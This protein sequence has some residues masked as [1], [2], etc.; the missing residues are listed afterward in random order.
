[1]KTKIVIVGLGGVGG[2]YGGMLAKNHID[3]PEIEIYFVAR[4]KHLK[5]VQENG[6]TLITENGTFQVVP[7][8]A[9]DNVTEIGTADYI[10]MTPKQL[11]TNLNAL[12]TLSLCYFV[13]V[14][15]E[16]M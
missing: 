6:L 14:L 9:T 10:I 5:K 7:T 8:L 16:F 2:Y 1:M 4:G 15:I 13:C 12:R 11:K 3:N